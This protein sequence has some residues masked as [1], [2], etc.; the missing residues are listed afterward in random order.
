[1]ALQIAPLIVAERRIL[2]SLYLFKAGIILVMKAKGL[3]A[4]CRDLETAFVLTSVTPRSP[5]YSA[6]PNLEI[7]QKTGYN[8]LI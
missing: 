7:G 6:K 1:M 2:I 3:T 5:R 8:Y 4:A